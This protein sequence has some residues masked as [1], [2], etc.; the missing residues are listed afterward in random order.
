MA[1]N[2][3]YPLASVREHREHKVEAATAELGSAV[4]ARETAAEQKLAAQR[5]RE[6]AAERAAAV[7]RAE[8]DK[9]A[10]GELSVADLVRA[11]AWQFAADSEI[12]GLDR[13]VDQASAR[14]GERRSAEDE[15]RAALAARKAD[16]DVVAKDQAKFEAAARQKQNA[17][18]E[19][20]AEEVYL[21]RSVAEQRKA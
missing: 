17:A 9:L 20:A 1:R 8:A 5:E 11:S 2:P 6:A 10:R 13:A 16:A 21:A 4:R 7:Q 14:L 3:K 18:E 19:E 12:A 15:A